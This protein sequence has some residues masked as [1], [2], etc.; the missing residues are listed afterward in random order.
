MNFSRRITASAAPVVNALPVGHVT[1][2]FRKELS[3]VLP[4]AGRHFFRLTKV[5][6]AAVEIRAVV[7]YDRI[8]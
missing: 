5:Y 8:H 6:H 7:L 1:E 4:S 2:A 3:P